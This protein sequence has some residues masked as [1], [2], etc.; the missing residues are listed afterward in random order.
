[1]LA[2]GEEG[3]CEQVY[4]IKK[5]IV[6]IE[7]Q[8]KDL[9]FVDYKVDVGDIEEVIQRS[10]QD[11]IANIEENHE[12]KGLINQ[13]SKDIS[14]IDEK[15]VQN[16]KTGE[17]DYR[18]TKKSDDS[19]KSLQSKKNSNLMVMKK[20]KDVKSKNEEQR[21][22]ISRFMGNLCKQGKRK[23]LDEKVY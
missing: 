12:L 9:P 19:L 23:E 16:K 22:M 10:I 17:F 15:I 4:I 2:K 18:A 8:L 13:V 5:E 21:M 20:L 14:S 11:F 6:D 7:K 3:L 1:M